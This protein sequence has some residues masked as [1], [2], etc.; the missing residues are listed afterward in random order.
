MDWCLESTLVFRL[1]GLLPHPSP[2]PLG[3]GTDEGA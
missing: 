1:Q 3:E 2:L